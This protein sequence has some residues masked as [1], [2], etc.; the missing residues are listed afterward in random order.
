MRGLLTLS[1]WF[2]QDAI[3]CIIS[4]RLLGGVMAGN[5][6]VSR[7]LTGAIA[8]GCALVTTSGVTSAGA[9]GITVKPNSNLVVGAGSYVAT[10]SA[11]VGSFP[12]VPNPAATPSPRSGVTK[13]ASKALVGAPGTFTAADIGRFVDDG[14]GGRIPDGVSVSPLTVLVPVYPRQGLP[15][16]TAVNLTGST[17]TMSIAATAA[18]PG[19]ADLI[20]PAPA[21]LL[22]SQSTGSVAWLAPVPTGL[23]WIFD[24]PGNV[25]G[26]DIGNI[27]YGPTKQVV[28]ADADGSLGVT[29]FTITEGI[30]DGSLG[31]NPGPVMVRS[32]DPD[33]PGGY[34][35]LPF[36]VSPI[37]PAATARRCAPDALDRSIPDGVSGV[38]YCMVTAIAL[39]AGA[40]SNKL[41]YALS[42]FPLTWAASAS[43]SVFGSSLVIGGADFANNDVIVKIVVANGKA[44][45]SSNPLVKCPALNQSITGVTADALGNVLSAIPNYATGCT[46][47][48]NSF[49]KVTL[50]GSKDVQRSEIPPNPVIG[51]SL[52][53]K[54]SA[55]I[56]MASLG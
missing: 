8:I 36:A 35:V 55:L 4:V 41:P 6:R 40:Q 52:A 30:A 50:I 19:S 47:P 13:V 11:P 27:A 12:K 14:V 25:C 48:T 26:Y 29:P 18:G 7:G 53:K 21:Q 44:K 5:R 23:C 32:F 38:D 42:S 51:T 17:A 10:V 43:G 3:F 31:T 9:V 2:R 49:T 56:S 34:P 28:T 15:A 33:G 20:A 39:N 24:F 37:D 16:I 1:E 54:A 45:L 22:V 46:V